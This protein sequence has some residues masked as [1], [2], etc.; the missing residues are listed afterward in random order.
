MRKALDTYTKRPHEAQSLEESE[1]GYRKLLESLSDGVCIIQFGRL[2]YTNPSLCEISGYHN[3]EL[4]GSEF[5]TY[6]HPND[7]ERITSYYEER[8]RGNNA[9]SE[10]DARIICRDGTEKTVRINSSII[11]WSGQPAILVTICDMTH[12]YRIEDSIKELNATLEQ[13]VQQEVQRR[14]ESDVFLQ[15]IFDNSSFGIVLLGDNG[16]IVQANKAFCTLLGYTMDDLRKHSL[17]SLLSE[18]NRDTVTQAFY[19]LIS[20]KRDISLLEV[21]AK[22]LEQQFIS[23]QI[24]ATSLRDQNREIKGVFAIIKDITDIKKMTDRQQCQEQL[25]IQQSKMATM[26][27]MIGA[28]THQWRQPLTMLELTLQEIAEEH[29]EGQ[30]TRAMIDDMAHRCRQHIDFMSRTIED[31]SNFFRP[32]KHQ[33]SF[34]PL[35]AIKDIE[36]LLYKQLTRHNVR[37]EYDIGEIDTDCFHITTIAN[38]FKQIVL[39]IIVNAIDAIDEAR[40]SGALEQSESGV[41]KVTIGNT[42]ASY[43]FSFC[44]NGVGIPQGNLEQVFEPYFTTKPGHKGTGI[45]LYLSR[46][47]VENSL[48]GNITASNSSSGACF[49]LELPAFNLTSKSVAGSE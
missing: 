41:I 46:V 40:Y 4:I 1:Q 18:E 14:M 19:E 25:L 26:G 42:D 6:L 33:V 36:R 5:Y 3:Q 35:E 17:Q 24:T 22:S 11:E 45:G 20:G 38:E 7:R 37:L 12:R 29:K 8:M 10:Y 16:N 27:E 39:N 30:L 23:M 15:T 28:I 34:N 2:C 9:P 43:K 48:G 44:D 47:I 13:R 21:S 31:F 32:D 49:E